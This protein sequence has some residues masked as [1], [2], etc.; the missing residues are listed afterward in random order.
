MRRTVAGQHQHQPQV[1]HHGS[2]L[3]R[4]TRIARSLPICPS[5]PIPQKHSINSPEATTSRIALLDHLG[6]ELVAEVKSMMEN[7]FGIKIPDSHVSSWCPGPRSS[8]QSSD[9]STHQTKGIKGSK[10]GKGGTIGLM[11]E[12]KQK[13]QRIEARIQRQAILV[14]EVDQKQAQ[15]KLQPPPPLHRLAPITQD[16][17]TAAESSVSKIKCC[18]IST[19]SDG[20]LVVHG[21]WSL[22]P[23]P[24]S[25]MI[26]QF[27]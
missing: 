14:D 16:A 24:C 21:I 2:P 8:V 18:S 27:C 10:G 9:T 25:F 3:S 1:H 7:T 4:R 17:G 13:K 6:K 19:K 5:Q 15:T 12:L 11:E 23:G 22:V 20:R 26:C